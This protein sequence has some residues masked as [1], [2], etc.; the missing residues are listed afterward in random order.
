MREQ[1]YHGHLKRFFPLGVAAMLV[2]WRWRPFPVEVEGE[3]MAPA[4]EPGDYLVAVRAKVIQ[5]GS[6][7]V[8]ELP[9]RPGYEMVK[10]V[11]GVPGDQIADLTMGPDEY[12]VL[13]DNEEGSTDSRTFGPVPR[14]AIHGQ[15]VLRYWPIRRVAWPGSWSGLASDRPLARNA[16]AVAPPRL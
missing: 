3:S 6:L 2:W 5:A 10:R 13:G 8:V 15:V 11:A 16:G 9:H 12:W 4:L 14:E 1:R 7:V